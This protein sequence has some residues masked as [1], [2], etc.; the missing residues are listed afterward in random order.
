MKS[1]LNLELFRAQMNHLNSDRGSFDVR[2]SLGYH[3]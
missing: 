1:A 3:W 2:L